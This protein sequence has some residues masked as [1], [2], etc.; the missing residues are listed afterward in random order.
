MWPCLSWS[1]AQRVGRIGAHRVRAKRGPMTGSGVIR[2]LGDQ[3]GGSRSALRTCWPSG[4]Q[5]SDR[6]TGRHPPLNGRSLKQLKLLQLLL[7]RRRLP[8]H[9]LRI[10]P[11]P[12]SWEACSEVRSATLCVT[13]RQRLNLNGG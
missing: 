3:D 13:E 6:L 7:Q 2:H 10:R 8:K 5:P 12:R 1:T 9:P 4:F 11:V